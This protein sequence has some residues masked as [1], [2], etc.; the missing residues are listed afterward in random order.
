M[1]V[2]SE[3]LIQFFFI[4]CKQTS[5]RKKLF[6]FIFIMQTTYSVR[7]CAGVATTVR[8]GD[9]VITWLRRGVVA[10]VGSVAVV[11]DADP[12]VGTLCDVIKKFLT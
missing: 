5:M 3:F 4:K 2:K 1:A 9:D 11:S 10:R 12:L 6:S 7:T 8:H